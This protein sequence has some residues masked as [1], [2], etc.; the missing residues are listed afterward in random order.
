MFIIYERENM[1]DFL[2]PAL[3]ADGIIGTNAENQVVTFD[4]LWYF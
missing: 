3:D 2:L 4:F 1:P